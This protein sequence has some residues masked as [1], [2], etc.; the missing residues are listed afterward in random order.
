MTLRETVFYEKT[1]FNLE[2]PYFEILINGEKIYTDE[3]S[4]DYQL[5]NIDLPEAIK[6]DKITITVR[7]RYISYHYWIR[8]KDI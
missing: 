5:I 8:K 2:N 7:G 3:I 4:E 6:E 1:K